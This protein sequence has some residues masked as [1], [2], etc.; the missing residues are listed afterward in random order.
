MVTIR[1]MTFKITSEK[2]KVLT[3]NKYR[4]V[5]FEF[6]KQHLLLVSWYEIGP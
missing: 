5:S 2:L 4:K 1:H 3:K 6:A